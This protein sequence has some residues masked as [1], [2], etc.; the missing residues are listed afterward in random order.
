MAVIFQALRGINPLYKILRPLFTD[1][2]GLGVI[3]GNGAERNTWV[4][5]IR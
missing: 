3:H 4:Y 2:L 1:T 5:D